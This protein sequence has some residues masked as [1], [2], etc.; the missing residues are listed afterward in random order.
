MKHFLTLVLPLALLLGCKKND[1]DPASQ[2][3]PATQTGANQVGC[4][5]N[6][7]PWAPVGGGTSKNFFIDYDPTLGSGIF[8]L[9]AYRYTGKATGDEYLVIFANPFKSAGSYNLGDPLIT[10]ASFDNLKVGCNYNSRD[11][12][13]YCRGTLTIT[14]LDTQAR[15]ISGTFNFTIATPGCDTLKVTQGRFDKQL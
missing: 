15:I 7:Q 14:R 12:G 3:P 13:T 1:P 9:S 6:G 5:I 8:A 10:R 4:L 2:L 11:A